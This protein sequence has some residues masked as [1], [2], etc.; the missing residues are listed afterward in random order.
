M[1]VICRLAVWVSCLAL[2][3]MPGFVSATSAQG[4]LA[5]PRTWQEDARDA[6]RAYADEKAKETVKEQSR[7][8]ITALY[9]KVYKSGAN[10]RLLRTLGEVAL[11]AEEINTLADNA[12]KAMT[13]GDPEAV[14][15]ASGQVAIALGRT[16]A[17]GLADPEL[18][19]HMI[20]ALGNVDQVNE[21][22]EALGS[23]AGGDRQAA[24]EYLGRALIAVTPAAGVVAAAEAIKGAMTYAH[25]KFVDGNIEDLYRDYAR[26]DE[27][28]RAAVRDRLETGGLYSYL[29]GTR[30]RELADSRA[31][32]IA[33]A[34]A[35]PSD[36]VRRRLTDAS[37]AEV[38]D[39]ILQTFAVR[40]NKDEAAAAA[41]NA[42]ATAQ[43]EADLILD[44]LDVS[45]RSK[46]GPDWWRKIPFN[47]SR[48]TQIVRE[49]LQEDG[50]LDP[51]NPTHIKAMAGLLSTRMIYGANSKEY[52]ERLKG[53]QNYRRTLQGVVGMDEVPPG[54]TAASKAPVSTRCAPGSPTYAES[55]K[56]WAQ[57]VRLGSSKAAAT[58]KR[59]VDI[60]DRSLSV[61]PNAAHARQRAALHKKW[62]MAFIGD[63]ADNV[64]RAIPQ[65]KP[66]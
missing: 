33:L 18:R 10:Q 30:R 52:E 27:E 4:S 25:G 32:D 28:A 64:R 16:L 5:P 50:I 1:N 40:R 60:A 7:A 44:S 35:E 51:H 9:K 58:I 48:Y 34:T 49:R 21:F 56:L 22:A 39:D 26:G 57:V 46:H 53:F 42:R 45:A 14:K 38:I 63:A 2:H 12:A 37:E 11:S 8:A 19:Q 54:A 61:C 15:A 13:S 41:E 43:A 47:L 31:A 23:A 6:A 24:Y 20:G 65:I 29:V 66:L 55:E 17:K 3:A 36:E 62:I 59:A